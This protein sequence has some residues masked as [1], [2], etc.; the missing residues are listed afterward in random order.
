NPDSISQFKNHRRII[1]SMI[2]NRVVKSTIAEPLSVCASFPRSD[3]PGS[4]TPD[5]F[6]LNKLNNSLDGQPR[7]LTS[8][9]TSAA[10]PG[11]IARCGY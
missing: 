1:N 4:A 5:R 3:G 10:A 6:G 8:L 2:G 11:T 9:A 7:Y